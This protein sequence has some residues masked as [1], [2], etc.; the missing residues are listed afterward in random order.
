MKSNLLL[1]RNKLKNLLSGKEVIE[2]FVFGSSIKGKA[3]PR[4]VDIAVLTYK[5]PS[6]EFQK[7]ASKVTGFHISVLTAK[8][9]F[10]NPPSLAHTLIREGYGLKNKK[11]LAESYKFSNKILF[12]YS[13]ASFHPPMKVKIVNILRGK[14]G[15]KG[16]VES[17]GGEWIANQVFNVPLKSEKIFDEFFDKFSVKFKKSY[18]LIH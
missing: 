2:I 5:K 10:I 11:F 15:E 9:F 12:S 18:I 13:V 6:L 3:L 1:I 17:N 7:K 4:D 8:E 14:K 16:I